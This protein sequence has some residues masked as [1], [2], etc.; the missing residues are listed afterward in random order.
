VSHVYNLCGGA[1]YGKQAAMFE[2]TRPT[3]VSIAERR[4]P[5]PQGRP[6]FLRVDTVHQGD[7]DGAMGVY[8]INTVD[9]ITQWQVVGCARKISEQF[10][11]PVLEAI[12]HQFP[13][14]ILGFHAD[15][16]SE[17]I[18]H[19]VAQLIEKLR[20]EFTKSRACRSQDQS[21][22]EGQKRRVIR[23]LIGYGHIAS[24]HGEELQKFYM[25]HFN[26]YLN[27]HRPCGYATVTVDARG[28]APPVL[29]RRRLR[30]TLRS[31]P[32]RGL[33]TPNFHDHLV[34]E[35]NPHFTII[36]GVGNA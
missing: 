23:K 27:Y 21:A 32:L 33:L 12:L 26:P 29:P 24:E 2:P 15:N 25:A 16:G 3:P 34:S 8:H 19:T 5:D 35:T 10:L 6:G 9:T 22:G 7:W 17:F 11:I 30:H 31:R 13:F 14:R 36:L 1:S 20:V 4:R 18:N 28:K